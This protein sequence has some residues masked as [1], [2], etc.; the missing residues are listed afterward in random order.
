MI[1]INPNIDTPVNNNLHF[2][3]I[4]LFMKNNQNTI[5]IYPEGSLD[6]MPSIIKMP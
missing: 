5:N 2:M 4:F 3:R 1:G 6:K